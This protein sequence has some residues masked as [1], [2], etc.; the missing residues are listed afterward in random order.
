MLPFIVEKNRCTG[1]SA[2]MAI[3]PAGCIKME[4]DDEGFLYPE[5]SN[6]CIHCGLCEK[7]CPQKRDDDIRNHHDYEKKVY[8]AVSKDKS[9]WLRSSSGGA[10]SEICRAWGDSQTMVVGAAWEGLKVSH[11]CLIGCE[12]ITPICKS[13][14]IYSSMNDSFKKIKSHLNSNEKVIFCGTPCQVSG[15]R[16]FLGKEYSNLLLIDLICHGVG[17]PLVFEKCIMMLEKK[18]GKKISHYEFRAKKDV[19]EKDYLSKIEFEDGSKSVYIEKDAYNQLFLR[20][21]ILRPSCGENCKYRSEDRQGD[22]TIADFKGLTS[23]FPELAGTKR[24]YSAIV[25]DS[26]KFE[27]II[28]KLKLNMEVKCADIDDIKQYNP[29]FYKQTFFSK[30]RDYFFEQFKND[31]FKAIEAY[32]RECEINKTNLKN[33]IY[34]LLPFKIRNLILSIRRSNNNG[35]K[36]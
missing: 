14:Y 27:N 8:A 32:T 36:K 23:V 24:N 4:E 19:Y 5:A 29:L 26:S 25:F 33:K 2:C 7:I 1:C 30:N 18:F 3:C 10:F 6:K 31:N 35:T 34:N 15:L 16:R 12:N 17:S 20:Q 9:V 28:E 22:I 21:D 13:K 11:K